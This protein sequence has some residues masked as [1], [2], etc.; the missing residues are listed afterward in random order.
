[1]IKTEII[2]NTGS[3]S[4][5]GGQADGPCCSK[6]PGSFLKRW[7][8]FKGLHWEGKAKA[9]TRIMGVIR[10]LM[11]TDFRTEPE[12]YKILIRSHYR[13]VTQTCS[14][15]GAAWKSAIIVRFWRVLPSQHRFLRQQIGPIT[16]I[17]FARSFSD[18]GQQRTADMTTGAKRAPISD[19]PICFRPEHLAFHQILLMYRT[20]VSPA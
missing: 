5:C 13:S 16:V 15:L 1:M 17:D 10:N 7:P 18:V 12:S 3:F 14:C 19:L 11:C 9:L 20:V 4:D 2:Y 6:M 8:K